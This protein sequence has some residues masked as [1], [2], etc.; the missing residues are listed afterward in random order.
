MLLE[1]GAIVD[2]LASNLHHGVR[3]LKILPELVKSVI[4]PKDSEGAWCLRIVP[5]TKEKPK[6]NFFEEFVTAPFFEG[7]N[8]DVR[9]LRHVCR[10]DQEAL[11]A[12]DRALK[13]GQPHG[14]DRRSPEAKIKLSNRQLDQYPSGDTTEAALRRLR[15][16]R[17]DLHERVMGGEL[18]PHAAAVEAGFRS[19][20][21]SVPGDPKRAAAIL[22][23]HFT[24]GD[25]NDLVRYLREEGP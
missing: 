24:A 22:R 25:L 18:S 7:L 13:Q 3:D 14:G 12:I 5:Q 10:D 16:Y 1:R 9:T 8:S 2:A 23:R 6:F 20:R 19:K 4:G 15:K 21:F 11:D 17:P